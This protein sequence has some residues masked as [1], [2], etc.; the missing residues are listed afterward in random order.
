MA[1]RSKPVAA[2]VG[3]AVVDAATLGKRLDDRIRPVAAAIGWAGLAA[4]AVCAVLAS[5]PPER[6]PAT[7]A[8]ARLP[9]YVT[10]SLVAASLL[11]WAYMQDGQ[12]RIER[13]IGRRAAFVLFVALPLVAAGI[14]LVEERATLAPETRAEWGAA[15]A[16]A[17]WYAPAAVVVSL[18]AWFR[19]RNAGAAHRRALRTAG[20]VALVA[21][22]AVLLAAL[23]FGFRLPW[24]E[25]PLRETLGV[26]GGSAVALQL[27][28][29]WFI[30]VPS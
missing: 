14:S 28:L 1:R 11:G 30:A 16:V 5:T 22:Y 13:R 10:L 21:P 8:P 29:A 27:V 2:R 15:F 17:R 18:V 4:L 7:L 25:Q 20:R 24:I 12:A 3:A 19:A 6:W 23:V 26:L 9:V